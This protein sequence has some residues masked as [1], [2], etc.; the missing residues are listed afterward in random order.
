[1][2]GYSAQ[3]LL[4]QES[5]AK[6]GLEQGAKSLPAGAATSLDVNETQLQADA[7]RFAAQDHSDYTAKQSAK[8]KALGEIVDG[9]S[10]TAADCESL[11]DD[12][13]LSEIV[14]HTREEHRASLVKLREDQ[15]QREAEL[16]AF[17]ALNGI[18]ENATY[19]KNM[20]E[21]YLLLA[22]LLAIETVANAYFYENSQGL[23]GGAVVAFMVSL[24]NLIVAF[25][26][27]GSF[28]YKNLAPILTKIGGWASVGAAIVLAIYF[29][30]IFS[31][32]RSEYQLLADVGDVSESA[33]AFGRAL[34]A[35]GLIFVGKF[36]ASDL[37][38][39]V[40]FFVGLLMSFL[41]FRK[42]YG[43]DDQYP[44]HGKRS[45]L[46]DEANLKYEG[47]LKI[48]RT[49][50]Q[51]DVQRRLTG[52]AAA[53]TQ[54]MQ[55]KPRLEQLKN[56]TRQE[57]NALQLAMAQLQRDFA[58]VLNTYRQN[59]V[60]VRPIPAPAYFAETPDIVSQYSTETGANFIS[61]VEESEQ[62]L[63][64]TK[65]RYVA[66]LNDGMRDLENEGRALQGTGFNPFL[67]EV[68]QEAQRNIESRNFT[69]PTLKQA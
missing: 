41:A 20:L 14:S 49:V 43:C 62:E 58:L 27:G 69:M 36:P 64:R 46:Y 37:M 56:S 39:F 60:S 38:S 24:V 44:G 4:K 61:S 45:R 6:K 32:Y 35:A 25:A 54:I 22:P 3:L 47:E 67:N 55:L 29:N 63:D 34:G 33:A 51:M 23:L 30:A 17:R 1:M 59:N 40:L 50:V 15:L 13:P 5:Y 42:G 57:L 31:A 16:K 19:P 52:M 18:T 53:K 26:L 65:E 28:R 48:V 11:L 66:R 21:P 2:A 7:Q 12:R 68:T 8:I 9:L 10:R